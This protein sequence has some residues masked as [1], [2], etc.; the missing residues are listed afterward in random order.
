LDALFWL[1]CSS[2]GHYAFFG[3][4]LR[5][6]V[7]TP[8]IY[9]YSD[10]YLSFFFYIKKHIVC[11][12]MCFEGIFDFWFEIVLWYYIKIKIIF[13]VFLWIFCILIITILTECATK[14]LLPIIH[15][16]CKNMCWDA[17]HIY[18]LKQDLLPKKK[19]LKMS[20]ICNN[21][22]Y[23]NMNDLFKYQLSIWKVEMIEYFCKY[24]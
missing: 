3:S 4:W 8:Y 9:I 2:W 14:V 23:I 20:I 17:F 13:F 5:K 21:L 12:L 22:I 6:N 24:E 10:I 11:L 7:I 19:G 18:A 15:Y 16:K 1:S